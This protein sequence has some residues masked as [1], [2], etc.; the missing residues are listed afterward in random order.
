MIG[1]K[2]GIKFLICSKKLIDLVL[3]K[4]SSKI[5]VL[6]IGKILPSFHCLGILLVVMHL[7]N[8]AV[9]A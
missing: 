3:V 6:E 1:K 5:G 7:L 8:R 4:I 2:F 9:I